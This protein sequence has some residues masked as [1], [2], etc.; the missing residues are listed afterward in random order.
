MSVFRFKQFSIKQAESAMKVG[1]DAMLL[2]ALVD[3]TNPQRVLDIGSGTG[4]VSLM[5]AQRFQEAK[6]TAIEIDAAS[7][8]ESNENFQN[9]PWS[10]RMQSMEADFLTH[11]FSEKFD[12]IVSNPPYFQ[13]RLE[14]DDPRKS[15][16]RHESALPMEAMIEKADNLL[17]AHG[18]FWVIVPMEVTKLWV[19][20]AEKKALFTVS[21]ISIKGKE[22]GPVKRTILCFKSIQEECDTSE[23]VI[24]KS[25]GTYT[26]QYIDLTEAYHFNDLRKKG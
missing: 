15:Q 21:K 3:G 12:L 26:D 18:Q 10:E 17:Q 8:Q 4:V 16:A 23:I 13:T 20:T 19:D 14:N 6:I 1:T 25:D 11:P 22:E 2:G 24:R 5:M 9:S 7:S